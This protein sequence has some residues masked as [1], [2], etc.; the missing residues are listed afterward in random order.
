MV[1]IELGSLIARAGL[2]ETIIQKKDFGRIE[3]DTAFWTNCAVGIIVCI[4]ILTVAGPLSALFTLPKLDPALSILSIILVLSSISAVPE[5]KLR[6]ALRF[7]SLATRTL[8]STAAGGVLGVGLA[9]QGYGMWSLVAA[10][11]GMAVSQTGL[12]WIGLGWSPRVR[13]SRSEFAV[14][15]RTGTTLLW[16]Q[17]L[18]VLNWRILD[19]AVGLFLGVAALGYFR[20]AWQG[21]M[22]LIQV[23]TS[24]VQITAFP[25]FARMQSDGEQLAR[26][27]IRVTQVCSLVSFPVLLGTAAIAPE[28]V[29]IAYGPAWVPSAPILQVLCL[30][31]LPVMLFQ[32]TTPA[33]IAVNRA[34][35]VA[36]MAAIQVLVGAILLLPLISLGPTGAALTHVA[37]GFLV[38]PFALWLLSRFVG[39]KP[40]HTISVLVP[41]L[42]AAAIMAVL[43]FGLRTWLYPHLTTIPLTILLVLAGVGSYTALLL[44]FARPFLKDIRDTLGPTLYSALRDSI[45]GPRNTH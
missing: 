42:L 15:S 43:V 24:A 22:L 11:I 33:V 6:R 3:A 40:S 10:R 19:I 8:L 41:S 30:A 39:V 25:I 18:G 35:W 38:L 34:G 32:F 17:L 7:R 36:V 21:F 45:L 14:L 13:F 28:I 9:L 12:L 1:F 5:G 29:V 23:T 37:R 44:G 20:L 2:P 26:T 31:V 4:V 27:F 16:S